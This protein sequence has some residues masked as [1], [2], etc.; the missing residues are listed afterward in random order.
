M[1]SSLT[2]VP[3]QQT[4]PE[5]KMAEENPEQR[6]VGMHE[7]ARR[8]K[9]E[10]IRDLGFDP[11]GTRFDDHQPIGSVRA[12]EDEIRTDPEN[13]DGKAE[14]KLYDKF[15]AFRKSHRNCWEASLHL[16]SWTSLRRGRALSQG[17]GLL[18]KSRCVGGGP[19]CDR[20]GGIGLHRDKS[21]SIVSR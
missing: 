11:W 2:E 14:Q 7:A 21:R 19:S 4:V 3:K 5:K 18:P 10:K 9:L 13:A 6:D 12:R 15:F 8:E 1:D 20:G 16:Y 17:R